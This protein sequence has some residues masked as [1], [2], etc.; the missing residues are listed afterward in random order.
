MLFLGAQKTRELHPIPDLANTLSYRMFLEPCRSS[1]SHVRSVPLL[2]AFGR[3]DILWAVGLYHF[4]LRYLTLK[5]FGD[6]G[7][8][9]IG[10]A[11]EIAA[12]SLGSLLIA[13]HDVSRL[14]QQSHA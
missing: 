7:G 12:V 5:L 8:A 14:L 1:V 11:L 9:H 2:R 10:A 13:C 3:S 4:V 6:L